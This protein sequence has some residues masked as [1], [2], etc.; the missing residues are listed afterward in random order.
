MMNS[1]LQQLTLRI[2]RNL[3]RTA[4]E[5]RAR[6]A[7]FL[8]AEQGSD[9][10]FAGRAGDSDLYYTGF[11]LRGL[12][13]LDRLADPER[14]RAASFLRARMLQPAS[15]VDF[16]SLLYAARLIQSGGGPDVLSEHHSDWTARVAH[17]L[18][19]FRKSD[20]GYAKA[21]EGATGSTYHTFLV[22][23]CY[24]LIELPLPQPDRVV[25]FLLS[26]RRDDGGF[27]EVAPARRGGTNPTAAA[28]TL[29]GML[30]ATDP[31]TAAAAIEFL[32]RMQS[33]DGGLCANDRVPLADL[34][35]TFTAFLTLAGLG[36]A[37]QVNQSAL[38]QFLTAVELSTGGFRAGI[39][40]DSAD[41]E[42][43][44]YGLGTEA[45]LQELC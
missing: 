40:D 30:G 10:G 31:A 21:T 27:V 43:T 42:Y 45:L 3:A 11:A 34:L 35:S 17:A 20:G 19:S 39:W 44:F 13:C 7:G 5:Y 41:V 4:P 9:G 38:R 8:L 16:L 26:R 2:T 29:L 6:H 37:D 14:D 1:Y 15:V 23:L 12:A 36:A 33:D 28:M 18:E 25:E 32:A 22:A 24:E